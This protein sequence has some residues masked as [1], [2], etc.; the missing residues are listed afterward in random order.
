LPFHQ[1]VLHHRRAPR[2]REFRKS[3]LQFHA[4][5]P[6]AALDA[7]QASSAARP[8]SPAQFAARQLMTD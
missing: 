5:R 6:H 7:A 1:E 4:A 8:A 3:N 2:D